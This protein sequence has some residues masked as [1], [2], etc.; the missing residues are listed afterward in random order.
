[1]RPSTNFILTQ[2]LLNSLL[3]EMSRR[4]VVCFLIIVSLSRR[5]HPSSDSLYRKHKQYLQDDLDRF[6]QHLLQSTEQNVKRL[7]SVDVK[8]YQNPKV[9][10]S[11]SFV[12]SSGSTVRRICNFG[13]G[14]YGM[15]LKSYSLMHRNVSRS[16][17]E[18]NLIIRFYSKVHP[19]TIGIQLMETLDWDVDNLDPDQTTSISGMDIVYVVRSVSA[20][21]SHTSSRVKQGL[22]HFLSAWNWLFRHRGDR[23]VQEGIRI[24]LGPTA[25]GN[26]NR[27]HID[28]GIYGPLNF[29]LHKLT[30]L[31]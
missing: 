7:P 30:L 3:S 4:V 11:V 21:Q 2:S 23:T 14:A 6:K 26:D 28:G 31:V 20:S 5:V 15:I 1:M 18:G 9:K 12:P 8:F 27:V 29:T 13:N 10:Q 17:R 22:P 24:Y 16:F 19:A 25:K